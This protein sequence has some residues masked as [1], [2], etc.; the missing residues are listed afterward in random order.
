MRELVNHITTTVPS[1]LKC[2]ML[3]A[4]GKLLILLMHVFAFMD[5]SG[6]D[7]NLRS[8]LSRFCR[9]RKTSLSL[10][11]NNSCWGRNGLCRLSEEESN[12]APRASFHRNYSEELRMSN[13][14]TWPSNDIL[15]HADRIM[16]AC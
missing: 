2:L 6:Y 4:F 12:H 11:A 15:C 16:L 8:S 13:F 5:W 1:H 9:N 7:V 3:L 14:E 10:F